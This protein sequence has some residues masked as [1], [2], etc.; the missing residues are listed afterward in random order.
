MKRLSFCL[1]LLLTLTSVAL[2][3]EPGEKSTPAAA[4]AATPVAATS[5]GAQ[6]EGVESSASPTAPTDTAANAKSGNGQSSEPVKL[7][8]STPQPSPEF[9]VPAGYRKVTK[10]L[11]TVYCKSYTPTGSRMPQTNCYTAEQIQQLERQAEAQRQLMLEKA[12]NGGT[13]GG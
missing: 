7:T 12:R 6:V 11:T 13:N 3:A 9:H 8:M 2:A 5:P 10:G 1:P 4:D